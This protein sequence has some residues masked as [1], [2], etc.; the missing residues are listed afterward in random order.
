MRATEN[1]LHMKLCVMAVRAALAAMVVLPAAH[2]AESD[3]VAALTQPA[4]KVELG[5]QNVNNSNAKFGEYNGLNQSGTSVIGNVDLRGGAS[6]DS[7]SAFRWSVSG[8][9]LGLENRSIDAEV[10]DQGRF[11]LNYNYDELLRNYSDQYQTFYNGAGSTALKLPATFATPA[12]A[13][14]SANTTTAAGA[15]S[16]WANMQSPYATAAC[17]TTGGV[18]TAACAGP[19]ILIPAAMHNFDVGTQRVKHALGG[20]AILAPGWE[21]T[22]SAQRED[23]QGTKL[24]GVA[25]G[26][27]ARG[28]L[29]PEVINSSTDIFRFG[30][31][32]VADSWYLNA[33]YTASFYRNATDTWTVESPFQGNLLAPSFGNNAKLVGAPD[34]QMHRFSLSGGVSITPKTRLTVATSTTRMTQDESFVTGLPSTWSIPETSAHAKVVG[35]TANV[36]LVDRSVPDLTLSAQYKYENRDNRTPA[37]DFK[38]SGGDAASAPNVFSTE[39]LNRRMQ[40]FSVE[41]D[42]AVARR[43][44][45]RLGYDNQQIR[46]TADG[47]ETPFRAETTTEHTVR[48]DYRNNVSPTVTGRFGYA[49]SERTHSEYEEN[50]LLPVPTVAPLPAADPLLPGFQQFYLADRS[51]NQ[52]R[53]ALNIQANDALSFQTGLDYNRDQFKNLEYG[54]KKSGSW[55]FKFDAA[56]AASET[57]S[58]NAFYTLEHRDSQ[59]DSLTIG[60]GSTATI[61]DKAVSSAGSTCAGYFAASGH[62]P[63]DEGTDPCRA[64]TV[65]QKDKTHTFGFGA[66]AGNL[67]GG[68]M[69]LSTDLALSRSRSPISVTG[70]AYFG[71]GNAAAAATAAV[72]FNNIFIAAQDFPDVTSNLLD[73]RVNALYKYSKAAAVHMNYL[74]RRLRS[75]DWQYDAYAFN[76]APG[77]AVAIPT[78]PGNNM[79]A[80]NYSVQAIGVSLVYTFR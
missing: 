32:H 80:P 4:N 33:N 15:L 46:R 59:L 9:N 25:F 26:G 6:Y 29:V 41:G 45:L 73:L 7:N 22:M 17:A 21:L 30:L 74:W 78:Y 61:L 65:Q 72:P 42:Y 47:D 35:S 48:L 53:S 12:A 49:H 43:Q 14:L 31:S 51:R 3:E 69:E 5:L 67:L 55:V 79:T 28:V 64:W 56:L 71:N 54:Q 2:G 68:K 75:N 62:L 37:M 11:R 13:R 38:V 19:G 24:T 52:L 58:Y 77:G 57:L 63:A 16:N 44:S 8:R 1:S 10:G 70:G 23:K 18:P 34:N 20:S 50:I 66:K 39:P 36:G 27:P 40:Q 60:R 76:A